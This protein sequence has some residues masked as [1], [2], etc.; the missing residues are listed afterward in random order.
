MP[1]KALSG[2]AEWFWLMAMNWKDVENRP[3]SLFKYI[4]PEELP[5][6]V[7]LHASK[8]KTPFEEMQFIKSQLSHDQLYA[9]QCIDFESFRGKLIAKITITGEVK[10]HESRWA[11][12]PFIFLVEDGEFLAR[13]IP[14]R[15][16][17]GFFVPK[18]EKEVV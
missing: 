14:Y 5:I 1:M 15:G 12:G 4:K 17:L 16:Q 7:Y 8:T 2:Y 11:F 18:F 3:W 10:K 6:R 13:P 9:F